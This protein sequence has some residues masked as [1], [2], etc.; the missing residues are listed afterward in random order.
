MVVGAEVKTVIIGD[1]AF[2]RDVTPDEDQTSVGGAAYYSAVGAIAAHR[3]E[4]LQPSVGIVATVGGDFDFKYLKD[5][6]IN[7]HG[8]EVIPE[9]KTCR[10]TITQYPDNTRKFDAQ[11]FVAETVRPQIYPTKFF[12][13]SH[14][15]LATS[16]PQNY[17]VWQEFLEG[18][19]HATV[20]ADAFESFATQFPDLSIAVLNHSDLIF[21]NEAEANILSH[22]GS[23][24]SDIPWVLKNGAGGASYIDGNISISIPAPKVSTVETT[25]AGD[26]LAGAFLSLISH[27]F[28]IEYALS[29]AV[30]IASRSVTKF[31]VEHLLE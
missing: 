25:G 21:L 11:R 14:I 28:D 18:K 27:G 30:K 1:I 3:I 29:V 22:K 15:H 19:T 17:L 31:G 4:R 5:K 2:N 10:F 6:A 8:I 13:A 12:S 20:S 24:R 9:G 26:V 16:L 7:T 23:L